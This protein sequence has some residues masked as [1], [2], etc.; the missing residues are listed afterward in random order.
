MYFQSIDINNYGSIT[1]FHYRF[2]FDKSGHPIPLVLI[3]E[4]GTGKTL[5]IANLVDALIEIKRKTYRET[6]FEVNENNYYKIGSKNYISAGQ[7]SSRVSISLKHAEETLQYTDI[8]SNNPKRIAEDKFIIQEEIGKDSSFEETGFFRSASSSLKQKHYSEFVSLYFPVDRFYLPLWYNNENYNRV[9]YSKKTIINQPATNIIKVDV[10]S[11]I[12]DWLTYIYLQT[13]FQLVQLPNA[14][15]LP[16]AV[17]GKQVPVSVD[18]N[19][20]TAIKKSMNAIFGTNDYKPRATDRRSQTFAFTMSGIKCNDISQ[21]SEGQ[22]SLFAIALSIIKE[23]DVTH[24][25]FELGDITGCVIID[26]ADLGLH[27]NYMHDCFPRMMQLFPNVQFILTTHSPFMI[28][29]LSEIYGENID[30]LTMPE[31]LKITDINSFSEVQ[32]AQEIVNAEINQIREEDK[33]LK[34]ELERL[35]QLQNKIVLY[36]EGTTDEILIKKALD[37]LNISDFTIEVHAASQNRGKHNDDAIKKLLATLQENP[38]VNN[39]VIGLFDRDAKPPVELFNEIGSK[40]KIID[41]EFVKLGKHVFAF[42]LPVPHNR[43]EK[44]QI[45]IEHFFTDEEI[46]TETEGHLRLFLGK[47]FYPSGNHIDDSK[48]YNYRNV[49][50]FH[51]SIRIIEHEQNAFVTDRKGNG[52]YSLSKQRFAEAVRD[53]RP[54]F[55]HFDFSEF[56]KIFNVIRKILAIEH[57]GNPDTT[58]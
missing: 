1:N 40:V 44:E 34:G 17:R 57:G 5:T 58:I 43:P 55:D 31:G 28:A 18:S 16:E 56:N 21:L 23:W 50:R 42:A 19:I 20:Q 54:G 33:K 51:G 45:S 35:R 13:T 30:I 29:G 36:T 9:E 37:K 10:L 52:D 12:K 3:G 26:E 46:M 32:I 24:D 25:N 49:S 4:N 2:R 27:I 41:H 8:M 38:C 7:N 15:N 22:M 53:D 6:L 48:D 14:N 11:N 39:T 47:E